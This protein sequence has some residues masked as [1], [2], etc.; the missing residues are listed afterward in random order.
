MVTA[1]VAIEVV[2]YED[3]VIED[4]TFNGTIGVGLQLTYALN[5]HYYSTTT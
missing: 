4:P 2:S 1:S 3:G 5:D